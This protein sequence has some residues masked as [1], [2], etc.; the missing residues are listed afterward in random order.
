[1]PAQGCKGIGALP[2]LETS[3]RAS[4]LR[5]RLRSEVRLRDA[6]RSR[7]RAPQ[8][9]FSKR[10]RKDAKAKEKE[11]PLLRRAVG[12][13]CLLS[14]NTGPAGWKKRGRC[15]SG[16]PR[17]AQPWT[18]KRVQVSRQAGSFETR[19]KGT[20]YI[21]RRRAEPGCAT[22][23]YTAPFNHSGAGKGHIIPSNHPALPTDLN[24][25]FRLYLIGET[26]FENANVSCGHDR[27]DLRR[28]V[29]CHL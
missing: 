21:F 16:R 11:R 4:A 2:T 17:A 23:I 20:A 6:R 3:S 18:L 10:R 7:S 8:L 29:S 13:S 26:G 24:I 19:K 9:Q 14:K 27:L 15:E 25:Q 5:T 1:M 28:E 22:K 12:P